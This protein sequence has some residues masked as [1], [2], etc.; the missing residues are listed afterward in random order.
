MAL[1][2]PVLTM[3]APVDLRAER[4]RRDVT[5]LHRLGPRALHEFLSELA[6]RHLLRTEIEGLARR[7][8][9]LDRAILD[10][11]GIKP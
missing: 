10:A 2:K 9:R 6:T 1:R 5:K 3:A 8:G 7:Y 4:F 11:L